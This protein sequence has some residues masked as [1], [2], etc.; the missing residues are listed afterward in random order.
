VRTI[1]EK[2]SYRETARLLVEQMRDKHMGGIHNLLSQLVRLDL[3]DQDAV[4]ALTSATEAFKR[5]DE[6]LRQLQRRLED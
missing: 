1:T 6:T 2:R 5:L 3:G 4:E